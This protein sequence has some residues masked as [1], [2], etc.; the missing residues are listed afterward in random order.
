MNSVAAVTYWVIVAIWLTVLSTAVYFYL[1]NRQAFGTTRLL[2]LVLTLD[3]S[4]NVIENVYFGFYFGSKYGIFSGAVAQ[5]LGNPDLLI[6]PKLANVGAGCVVL[7]L[8]LLR[9]LPEAILE[10]SEAARRSAFLYELAT[11][12]EMTGLL[13]RRHFMASAEM[14]W[15]RWQRY[16]RVMSLLVLDIDH[17]KSVNDQHG[18]DVGDRVIVAVA[19]SCQDAVRKSDIAGRLGGEEFGILLLETG[20]ADALLFAERLREVISKEV[21]VSSLGNI[22]ST[23]S[24]G[25]SASPSAASVAE[26]F[27]QADL[28]LYQAKESGR[29]RVCDFTPMLTRGIAGSESDLV[30]EAS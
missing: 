19:R 6:L 20:P 9:W 14:E 23:V 13:N 22:S 10:R 26:L 29:N 5:T 30:P 17:F 16:Q 27:K 2:L 3:A 21:V 15:E 28:A 25:V 24:V 7:G 18:H 1:T 11:T 12:D 8:L 4:R